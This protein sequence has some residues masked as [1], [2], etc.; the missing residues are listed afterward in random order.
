MELKKCIGLGVAGNFTGHLEQAGEAGDFT[1]V[2]VVEQHQPKGMFP[3]Y[4]PK[5]TGSFLDIYPLTS[6][7]IAM[8]QEGGNLQI[9]PEIAIL[10]EVRYENDMVAD[11]IPKQF[12]AYN[13]CSIRKPGA[14]KISEKKNWG[15]DSKGISSQLL[16]VDTFTEGSVL[17]KYRIACFLER[18]SSVEVYGVDSPVTG[19]SYFY[20]KLKQWM[21][22]RMNQQADEGPLECLLDLIQKS[23]Y[24]GHAL[25]SIGATRYTEFGES[26]FLQAGDK[27][28]IVVYDKT[29]NSS[30][31][32]ESWAGSGRKQA[33]QNASVLVQTVEHK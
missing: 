5:T 31:D 13:D 22:D 12:G 9:E 2:Q 4:L 21:I 11:L 17:E 1:H 29:Q 32:I 20:E 14:K 6:D 25:I 26:H 18:G 16:E 23:G 8:P 7:R 28:I 30:G 15:T 3:F 19:Y 33:L 10:F 24:P 27:S